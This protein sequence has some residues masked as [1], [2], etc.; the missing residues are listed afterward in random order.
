MNSGVVAT[1]TSGNKN[2]LFFVYRYTEIPFVQNFKRTAIF[3]YAL[4]KQSIGS[5]IGKGKESIVDLR[6]T[7]IVKGCVK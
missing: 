7:E 4:S 6:N 3:G 1:I 2:A 5:T